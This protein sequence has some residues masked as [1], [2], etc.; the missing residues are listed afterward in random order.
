MSAPRRPLIG[1]TSYVERAHWGVWEVPAALVPHGY[2]QAIASHG[3]R[4]LILP[5]DDVDADVLDVLDGL[6]F[7]GGADIDPS[8]YGAEPHERTI[9]LRPDRDAGELTLM[10]A[11]LARDLP[12]LG[13]CRGGQLMAVAHGGALIQHLPDAVGTDDHRPDLGV[14]GWHR[15]RFAEGSMIDR[16]LDGELKVNSYHHQGIADAGS[17]TV[18]GWAEDGTVEAVEDPARRFLL[19]V[20]WHPEATEDHRLFGALVE[21]TRA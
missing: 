19:G 10:R 4:A 12:M 14:Y 9:G 7:A 20:Q 17:L 16:V 1:V 2:V 3:G 6:V 15:V 11:A 18:V 5:P 21:A 13:V 8:L